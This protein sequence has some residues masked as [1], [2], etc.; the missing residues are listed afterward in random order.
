MLIIHILIYEAGFAGQ[1]RLGKNVLRSF[2]SYMVMHDGVRFN[3]LISFHCVYVVRDVYAV[4]L[5]YLISF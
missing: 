2:D 4:P 5:M 1:S 3:V